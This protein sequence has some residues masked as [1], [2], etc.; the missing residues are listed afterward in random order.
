MKKN[1]NPLLAGS[2]FSLADSFGPQPALL[3]PNA[4]GVSGQPS[5]DQSPT[6]VQS[7]AA[8]GFLGG[9]DP[10]PPQGPPTLAR[11]IAGPSPSPLITSDISKAPTPSQP[12]L[13]PS[14]TL[15]PPLGPPQP[16]VFLLPTTGGTS[17]PPPLPT[18]TTTTSAGPSRSRYV[19]PPNLQSASNPMGPA[20][21]PPATLPTAV[22]PGPP[23]AGMNVPLSNPIENSDDLAHHWFFRVMVGGQEQWKPFTMID[24]VAIEDVYETN[25]QATEPIPTDGGR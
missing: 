6:T 4:S 22:P 16:G 23:L 2:G 14:V 1:A 7:S 12:L 3:I 24:S 10:G 20:T 5:R 9:D 11:D 8:T 18:P 15:A 13:A 25:P 17:G 19:V 21:L